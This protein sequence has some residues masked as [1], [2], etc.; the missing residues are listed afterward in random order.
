MDA[1]P[2]L[3]REY[4]ALLDRSAEIE[5]RK[6]ELKAKI[7]E[8][9]HRD[10]V[11]FANSPFGSARKMARFKLSPRPGPVLG[12][13]EREDLLPFANFTSARVTELLVPKYGRERLMPLFDVEKTEYL[14]VKRPSEGRGDD[15][16]R[17]R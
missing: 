14:L 9:M 11:A 1:L 6:D 15:D 10:G 12:L 16:G 2:E 4:A 8:A 3:I 7:Q 13:L 5:A 17:R